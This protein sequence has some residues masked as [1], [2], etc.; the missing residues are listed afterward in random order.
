MHKLDVILSIRE[1]YA[2]G[3]GDYDTACVANSLFKDQWNTSAA[4]ALCD[5][6]SKEIDDENFYGRVSQ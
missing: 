2:E 5:Q 1:A 4:K 3:Y 6:L